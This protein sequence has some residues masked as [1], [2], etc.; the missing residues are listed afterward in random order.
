MSGKKMREQQGGNERGKHHGDIH[1]TKTQQILDGD[2]QAQRGWDFCTEVN[3]CRQVGLGLGD[4]AN[5]SG[6]QN[7]LNKVGQSGY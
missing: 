6:Y 5:D 4:A 3:Q 7:G 1:R 2:I